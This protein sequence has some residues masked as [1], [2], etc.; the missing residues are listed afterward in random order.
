MAAI[1]A[2]T[3]LGLVYLTQ[4]L[5]SNAASSEIRGLTFKSERLADQLRNQSLAI[6]QYSDPEKIIERATEQGLGPIADTV[7]LTVP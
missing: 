2:A 1:I 3:M 7:I 4:T 5:G 6:E